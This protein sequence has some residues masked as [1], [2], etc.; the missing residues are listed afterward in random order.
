MIEEYGFLEKVINGLI[1]VFGDEIF[2]LL[3]ILGEEKIKI[4]KE[5][6]I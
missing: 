4:L 6:S 3:C 1:S 5:D 2:K